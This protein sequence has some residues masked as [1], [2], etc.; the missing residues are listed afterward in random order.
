MTGDG[1]PTAAH[2][3]LTSL[4]TR[5]AVSRGPATIFGDTETRKTFLNDR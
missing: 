5:A 1:S 4:L 3:S 2:V